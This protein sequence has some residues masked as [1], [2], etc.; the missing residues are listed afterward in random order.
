M[1]QNFTS[2]I[3]YIFQGSAATHLRCGG[4]WL[5]G[6]VVNLLEN[7]SVKSFENRPTFIKV[8]NERTVAQFF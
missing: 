7:T 4:Q 6:F 5:M 3:L 8:M 1:Q 2:F